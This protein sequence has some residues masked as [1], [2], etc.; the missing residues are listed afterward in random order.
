MSANP[1]GI[2]AEPRLV[3]PT[4]GTMSRLCLGFG[5]VI[6]AAATYSVQQ[7][8]AGGLAYGYC[9]ILDDSSLKCWGFNS[10]GQ[11]GTWGSPGS[12]ENTMGDFLPVID[13]GAGR[14]VQSGSL[15][16]ENLCVV[17]DNGEAKC[18]G[19][20]DYGQSGTPSLVHDTR[21]EAGQ[22]IPAIDLG[23][24]RTARQ[25]AAGITTACALLD[26]GGVKC[27]GTHSYGQLG[28]ADRIHEAGT[29]ENSMGDYLPLVDLGTGRTA[30]K[31]V[32]SW[33]GYCAILDDDSLKCWGRHGG[34]LGQNSAHSI[35]DP[36]TVDPI[37]LGESRTVF[38]I[39]AS[40]YIMCAI[41]DDG[42]VRC[43]GDGIDGGQGSGDTVSRG[44]DSSTPLG[45]NCK[46]DYNGPGLWLCAF[47]QRLREMLGAQQRGP[48]WPRRH[49]ESWG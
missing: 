20:N 39:A 15:G 33:V 25:V 34:T 23:I 16:L 7:L 44:S 11:F 37:N 45:P 30:K 4:F 24:G 27:W 10:E 17:L 38:D 6:C 29:S 46:A 32:H 47:G 35:G 41:L 1:I 8:F 43:W 26:N 40:R 9:V 42:T 12:S 2:K 13:V 3:F 31:I 21:L 14:T 48:A 28:Y 22:D 5:F 36:S 18:W 49:R 19:R